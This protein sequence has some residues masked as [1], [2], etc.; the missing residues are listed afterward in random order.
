MVDL[1]R[2]ERPEWRE[3]FPKVSRALRERRKLRGDRLAFGKRKPLRF[4]RQTWLPRW[5]GRLRQ[6]PRELRR[7]L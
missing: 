7:L 1:F 3:R 5:F 6:S 2:S 4:G